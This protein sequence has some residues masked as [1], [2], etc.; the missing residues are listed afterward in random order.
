MTQP[1]TGPARGSAEFNRQ[2]AE[3]LQEAS[4]TYLHAPTWDR[5]RQRDE[6]AARALPGRQ[7]ARPPR[8]GASEEVFQW[9]GRWTH[10][11]KLSEQTP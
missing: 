6:L 7:T 11:Q 8:G 10:H 4:V 9:E 5:L 2:V 3:L 1:R